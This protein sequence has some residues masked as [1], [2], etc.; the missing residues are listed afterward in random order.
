MIAGLAG[1]A[2]MALALIGSHT[3]SVLTGRLAHSC[4]GRI[5]RGRDRSVQRHGRELVPDQDDKALNPTASQLPQPLGWKSSVYSTL[6][7]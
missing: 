7:E 1:E 2:R 6:Q 5:Q 4:S 3:V